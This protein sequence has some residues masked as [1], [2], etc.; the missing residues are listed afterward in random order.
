MANRPLTS[1][2]GTVKR[3][4]ETADGSVK[5]GIETSNGVM[6]LKLRKNVASD[7]NYGSEVIHRLEVIDRG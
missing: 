3:M 6:Q 4:N 5:V 7:L 2:A 1:L